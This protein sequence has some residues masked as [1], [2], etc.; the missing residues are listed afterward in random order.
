[1]QQLTSI[2]LTRQDHFWTKEGG[3]TQ[4]FKIPFLIYLVG[5]SL[6]QVEAG[7]LTWYEYDLLSLPVTVPFAAFASNEWNISQTKCTILYVEIP[8]GFS[9]TG[10]GCLLT[11]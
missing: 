8:A 11:V 7:E 10:A 1:M 9:S 5:C 2:S 6:F 3:T 4:S